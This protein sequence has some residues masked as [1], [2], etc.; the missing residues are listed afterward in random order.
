MHKETEILE[1]DVEK[2]GAAAHIQDLLPND[3]FPEF[4]GRRRGQ[5]AIPAQI[6]REDSFADQGGF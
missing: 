1:L 6:G 2:F 4:F 3:L 5:G